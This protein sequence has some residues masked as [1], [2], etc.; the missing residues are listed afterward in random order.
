MCVCVCVIVCFPEDSVA[1]CY[2]TEKQSKMREF[3]FA[4]FSPAGK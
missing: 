4:V 1:V 3:N 2:G